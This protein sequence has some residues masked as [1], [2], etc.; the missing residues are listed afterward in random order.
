MNAALANAVQ[1]AKDARMPKD[2]IERAARTREP[3]ALILIDL[4]DFKRVNDEYGHPAGDD[5]LRS[6]AAA[7]AGVARNGD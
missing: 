5:V 1:K 4:D 3:Y 6:V 7:A 2:N